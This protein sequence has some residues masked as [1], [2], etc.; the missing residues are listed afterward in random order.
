MWRNEKCQWWLVLILKREEVAEAAD[1]W[2]VTKK[3]KKKDIRSKMYSL[4]HTQVP[5]SSTGYCGWTV[6]SNW[7]KKTKNKPELLV[8]FYGPYLRGN[9]LI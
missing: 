1:Q 9:T 3:K 4:S 7:K 5:Y 8:G 6:N 2:N